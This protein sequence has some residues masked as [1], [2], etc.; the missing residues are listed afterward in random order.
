MD[1]RE[2]L[3]I[4]GI[5]TILPNTTTVSDFW[6]NLVEGNSQVDFLKGFDVSNMS[7]KIAS[8]IEKFNYREFL[9]N[10]D[11]H[12]AQKYSREILMGMSALANA[13]KDAQLTREDIEPERIG[14]IE[15][16]SRGTLKWWSESMH[17]E[18]KISDDELFGSNSIIPGLN[19][20][21]ASMYAIYDNIQ[22][23]VT[24][25]S[26]ACVG[27]HQALNVAMKEIWS[28]S[29]DT[30]LVL[31]AEYP[32]VPEL[33]KIYSAKKSCVLS[34]EENNPKK[35]L[36][37]YD[38]YRNGFVLGEGAVALCIE[39]KKNAIKRGARIYCELLGAESI[40]EAEHATR[41]DLTGAKNAKMLNRLLKNI[42]RTAE[43]VSY[44]CAHGTGTRYNDLAECRIISHLYDDINKRPPMGSVKP[45]YGHLF[46]GA[47]ILNVAASA[48]MIYN[49]TLCPTINIET[50]DPECDFDHVQ[51]GARKTKV[52]SIVSM[53]HAIGSQSAMVAIGE[54]N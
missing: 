48:L 43:D 5:G 39:K 51:E 28:G 30:M 6:N 4:T 50:I 29:A 47:G 52:K 15:S 20:T 1:T 34:K 42:N 7:V 35:A 37:P 11:E 17:K 22:G 33:L 38:L 2:K 21:T 31:G 18:G 19:G 40:N 12:F 10:L 45:I 26:C 9:T 32:I 36:K 23:M 3:V 41:M 53:A 44:Y 54:V 14:I 27:G 25:I 46:G 13:R 16:S 49:Q 24:S 8:Q